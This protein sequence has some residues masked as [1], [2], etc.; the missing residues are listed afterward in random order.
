MLRVYLLPTPRV[1]RYQGRSPARMRPGDSPGPRWPFVGS[2]WT[3]TD[4]VEWVLLAGSDRAR[5]RDIARAAPQKTGPNWA[6]TGAARLLGLL[7]PTAL[8]C[9]CP[10]VSGVCSLRDAGASKQ[11]ASDC[12]RQPLGS[13]GPIPAS[14]SCCVQRCP[15]PAAADP[16][17]PVPATVWPGGLSV[18]RQYPQGSITAI[19]AVSAP[20]ALT[21]SLS[22]APFGQYPVAHRPSVPCWLAG[23]SRA[24]STPACVAWPSLDGLRPT[25]Y[26]S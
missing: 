7:P 19:H 25:A 16:R 6:P 4:R 26:S 17:P 22:F 1:D 3:R 9:A 18:G 8:L 21:I 5:A 11:L 24:V 20:G 23:G 2:G 14:P 12:R 10:S 15:E 13:Q